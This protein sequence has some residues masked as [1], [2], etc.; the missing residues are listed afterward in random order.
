MLHKGCWIKEV[1]K[2]P[3]P[4]FRL[5]PAAY[6]TLV[7]EV[8]DEARKA[9]LKLPDLT[10]GMDM[11]ATLDAAAIEAIEQLEENDYD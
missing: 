6:R 10:E 8:E 5:A 1:K 2:K 3:P 9:F 4:K 7:A 11:S